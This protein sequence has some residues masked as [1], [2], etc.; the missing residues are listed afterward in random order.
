MNSEITTYKQIKKIKPDKLSDKEKLV[1]YAI[2]RWPLKTDQ[3][4]SEK[5][6]LN[7]S[8][9]TAIKKRLKDNEVYHIK[10]R[11]GSEYI[12]EEIIKNTFFHINP[13]LNKEILKKLSKIVLNKYD[14]SVF[15]IITESSFIGLNF[16]KD[17]A[18]LKIGQY[19]FEEKWY[20]Q[21]IFINGYPKYV[22][23][24]L[25]HANIYFN[26][27]NLI[28]HIFRLE[29]KDDKDCPDM[30]KIKDRTLKRVN[31]NRNDKRVIFYLCK[32]PEN[33]S[34]TLAE[35]TGINIQTFRK[36][37]HKI[38]NESILK[39][40]IV[41]VLKKLDNELIVYNSFRFNPRKSIEER[42]EFVKYI[43]REHPHYFLRVYDENEY[44]SLCIYED[45][46]KYYH[47]SQA[48]EEYIAK[49]DIMMDKTETAVIQI[50]DIIYTKDVVFSELCKKVFDIKDEDIK[51]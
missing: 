20:N 43:D 19:N 12:N 35:I 15:T 23:F 4:L 50:N 1:L 37:K 24:A 2:T 48:I 5:I 29:I 13:N 38:L 17:F 7:R 8:T 42:T 51:L 11:I 14:N 47:N 16:V 36:I 34:K 49:N 28:K 21:N 30:I 40:V 46:S 3:E 18:K 25:T 44:V 39:P 26:Y 32:F 27:A 9:V 41:P 22:N 33:N 31:L 45:Y 10:Y 6:D